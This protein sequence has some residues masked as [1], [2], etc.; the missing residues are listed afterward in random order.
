MQ[1]QKQQHHNMSY[2]SVVSTTRPS[3]PNAPVPVAQ[4]Q[5][6]EKKPKAQ[7][8]WIKHVLQYRA[9][10][11]KDYKT[12]LKEA[13]ATYTKKPKPGNTKPTLSPNP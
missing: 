5:A 3:V 8:P 11:G 12:C 6:T 9:E 10:T 4:P 13:A 1:S 7:S 2:A